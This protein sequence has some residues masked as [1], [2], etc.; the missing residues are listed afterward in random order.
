MVW[1]KRKHVAYLE[2]LEA[3]RESR[4]TQRNVYT[5]EKM[6]RGARLGLRLMSLRCPEEP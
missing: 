3:V 2:Y 4:V 1:P 6:Q 5:T